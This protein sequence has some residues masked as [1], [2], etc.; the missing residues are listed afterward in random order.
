MRFNPSVGGLSHLR[1]FSLFGRVS[2]SVLRLAS[3]AVM[4][5][6]LLLILGLS[7]VSAA[8]SNEPKRVLIVSQEDLTWP[9]YRL[10][11][12]N[13]RAA[14][15]AGSPEGILIFSEHLDRVHFPDP[16][17]QEQQKAWIQRKYA[18][19]KID[20]VIAVADVPT[21]IFQ[22]VPVL[23]VGTD[24]LKKRP[25]PSAS[26]KD[27]TTIWIELD[28]RKTLEAARRLQPQARQVVV[29]GS[30]SPTGKNLVDQVRD[31]IGG[32][33]DHLPVIYLTNFTLPEIYEKVA[34]LGSESMVLYV[35]F[36]RDAAGRQFISTEVMSKINAVSKAPV[37][38]VLETNVGLGA[39]GGYVT[40]FAELGK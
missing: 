28:A 9:A 12:E 14:L 19:A 24:P 22:G 8:Q 32:D 33:L 23:H 10:I 21:D 26:A 11:D 40:S 2:R 35:S 29:I 34:T 38:V 13:A 7:S 30:S 39:V 3:I 27:V 5:R 16:K 31:Q 15:R 20:L 37:Y 25:S 36:A 4:A 17:F 18:D 1:I 6:T